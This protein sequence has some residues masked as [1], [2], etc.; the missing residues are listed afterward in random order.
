MS[1]LMLFDF[2]CPDCGGTDEYLCR[3]TATSYRCDH[4]GGIQLRVIS[5]TTFRLDGTD[6]GFPTAYAGW[7]KKRTS[8]KDVE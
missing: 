5:G 4:C 1:K 3:S 2:K 6:P 7:E 8:R